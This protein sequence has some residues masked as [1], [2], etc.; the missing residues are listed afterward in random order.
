MRSW[1]GILVAALLVA[2]PQAARAQ[3]FT[4]TPAAGEMAC[5]TIGTRTDRLFC[6]VLPETVA[7]VTSVA[8]AALADGA[9]LQATVS[10]TRE[11]I[12]DTAL[13]AVVDR[14]ANASAFAIEAMRADLSAL[15]G[16]IPSGSA[17]A[18]VLSSETGV[19]VAFGEGG[20]AAGR[21]AQG[22]QRISSADALVPALTAA[23]EALAGRPESRKVLVI[24]TDARFGLSSG[25]EQGLAERIRSAGIEINA[26]LYQ[27][28]AAGPAVEFL[29]GLSRVEAGRVV[30]RTGLQRPG[31][32][33]D[34]ERLGNA[35]GRYVDIIIGTR[36]GGGLPNAFR[37][38]VAF[39]DGTRESFTAEAAPG[40]QAGPSTGTPP[41]AER[42]TAQRPA[43][44]RTLEV[45][46]PE[47][48]PNR[49]EG[50]QAGGGAAT[51]APSSGEQTPVEAAPGRG[52]SQGIRGSIMDV[53]AEWFLSSPMRMLSLGVLVALVVAL[54]VLALVTSRRRPA[55]PAGSGA[56]AAPAPSYGPNAAGPV[57]PSAGSATSPAG[58]AAT[59]SASMPPAASP[60]PG[61]VRPQAPQEPVRAETRGDPVGHTAIVPETPTPAEPVV[62]APAVVAA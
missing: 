58:A 10:G 19:P 35:V 27:P 31:A 51:T 29:E 57:T 45:V 40:T 9:T 56:G 34:L 30:D 8:A 47:A 25:I 41:P 5:A 38:V 4:A 22:L 39:S 2:L 1:A 44:E 43:G 3:Q 17:T 53:L 28:N 59:A 23:L 62:A 60:D 15:L 13:V 32:E 61:T 7:S 18:L 54:I 24:A 21:L 16:A 12:A 42:D 6:T 11:A 20:A 55:A 52:Q 37:V 50:G 14:S 46:R 26:F 48:E 36:D 49:T 33:A